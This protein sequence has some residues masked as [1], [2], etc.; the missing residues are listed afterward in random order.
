MI[1]ILLIA[2]IFFVFAPII[3]FIIEAIEAAYEGIK[4]RRI[5]EQEQKNILD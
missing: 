2:F 4:K 3:A 1:E 5:M